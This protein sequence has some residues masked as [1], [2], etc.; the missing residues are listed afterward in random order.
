MRILGE[1]AEN[2][3]EYDNEKCGCEVRCGCFRTRRVTV[4]I[5]ELF[6]NPKG[7]LFFL[8]FVAF[9]QGSVISGFYNINVS[10]IEKRFSLRSSETGFISSASDIA[11]C[12]AIPIFT[13]IGG[14]G[15][16]PLWIGSGVFIMALGSLFLSI[17]HFAAPAYSIANL[18][19]F[20]CSTHDHDH[21]G[22]M[23]LRVYRSFFIIGQMLMGVGSTPL[24]T[25][26]LAY[27][28]ENV[29]QVLS[30]TYHGIFYASSLLGPGVG[31]LLG[32]YFLTHFTTM[33]DPVGVS[34]ENPLWVGNWWLGFLLAG[35]FFLL[36]CIPVLMFPEQ[37]PGTEKCRV[38]RE[39]ELHQ[40]DSI[41]SL[42]GD[43]RFG[44]S[45][46]DAPR[47]LLVFARNP[48][49]VIISFA[50]ALDSGMMIGLATFGPKYVESMFTMSASSAA[51]FFGLIAILTASSAHL[52]SGMLI[53]KFK[54]TVPQMLRMSVACAFIAF[55]CLCIFFVSCDNADIAGVFVPYSNESE[56]HCDSN[57]CGCVTNLYRPVCGSDNV[58]YLS[59]CHAGCSISS[60][61]AFVNCSRVGGSEKIA[62]PE[63]CKHEACPKFGLFLG[64]VSLAVFF[65]FMKGQTTLQSSLRVVPF[66]QRSFT[67]GVQWLIIRL[68]G[69]IPLP[70][71]YGR[72]LDTS[73]RT[74][75]MECGECGSCYVYDNHSMAVSMSYVSLL[76]KGFNL[77][78]LIAVNFSYKRPPG[79]YSVSFDRRDDSALLTESSVRM[80]S[81]LRPLT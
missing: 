63:A 70:I 75:G 22:E 12:F 36:L 10:T 40:Q 14:A 48:T 74:W 17:P 33:E 27:I 77:M 79:D 39:N 25:L 55:C 41:V 54:M 6:N 53:S 60:S 73:C 37:M 4:K 66:S 59:F 16:K 15:H 30:S 8:S 11:G 3:W 13:Y 35:I 46:K 50:N 38:N 52:I 80:H 43:S 45:I 78:L 51:F 9:L 67:V 18:G 71:I 56:V 69:C 57:Q 68:V 24:Y 2:I 34:S 44:K 64:V 47:S 61:G 62:E 31:Y 32:G 81:A 28:D 65:T 19:E 1:N 21:C 5:L 49:V 20:D 58:T 72:V 23:N 42:R 26:A 7:A 29:D 76:V